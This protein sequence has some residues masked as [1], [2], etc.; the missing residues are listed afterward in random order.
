MSAKTFS[1]TIKS[2]LKEAEALLRAID[3]DKSQL[4]YLYFKEEQDQLGQRCLLGMVQFS[5]RRT[6]IFVNN[7]F[8]VIGIDAH[9]EKA[10]IVNALYDHVHENVQNGIEIEFGKFQGQRGT[11]R[12]EKGEPVVKYDD[13][14]EYY[15][16]CGSPNQIIGALGPSVLK[17]PFR[18]IH[19]ELL[20]MKE[21]CAKKERIRKAEEWW[22][23]SAYAWQTNVRI[24][25]ER[26]AKEEQDKRILVIYNPSG[27]HGKT[28]FCQQLQNVY[29]EHSAFIKKT[30]EGKMSLQLKNYDPL[31]KFCMID[32]KGNDDEKYD[33]K[34]LH[35][36]LVSLKEGEVES[37]TRFLNV[38]V[39]IMTKNPMDWSLLASS[40]EWCV[41]ELEE[42]ETEPKLK[43]WTK[44]ELNT[45]IRDSLIKKYNIYVKE[46]NV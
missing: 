41:M 31:L 28:E 30:Y 32:Y 18:N 13:V 23:D 7:F 3:L 36:F 29:H 37:I 33:D 14:L 25:L 46:T 20:A 44:E 9:V 34:A 24:T 10:R 4:K 39:V 2:E 16:N 17:I 42:G 40:G 6:L 38:Q 35:N 5:E 45:V 26:W 8:I 27:K 11:K 1:V 19:K 12:D 22:K 15:L 43:E 21:E